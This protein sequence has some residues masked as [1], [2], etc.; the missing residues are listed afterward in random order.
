[1]S[2]TVK[3][4]S[5]FK[6]KEVTITKSGYHAIII[7]HEQDHLNGELFIDKINKFDK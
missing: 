3:G 5:Y 6:G 2:V 7:Q 1:M 4:Y